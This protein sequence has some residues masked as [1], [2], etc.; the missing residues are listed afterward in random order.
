MSL[1]IAGFIGGQLDTEAM[2]RA[3]EPTLKRQTAEVNGLH[4]KEK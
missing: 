4:E 2:G 3:V 1:E